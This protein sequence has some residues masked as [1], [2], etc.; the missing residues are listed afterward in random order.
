MVKRTPTLT[1]AAP[2]VIGHRGASGYRPEHTLAAYDLA[3]EQGVSYIEPD[4]VMTR[5]RVL[6]VRHEPVLAS[7]D[8]AGAVVEATTNVH[9]LPQYASRR[10]TRTVDGTA[11]TGW[12]AQ[13]FTLA[14]IKT[15]KARERLPAIRPGNVAFLDETIPTLQEVIDLATVRSA[16]LG[17]TIGVYPEL[18]HGTYHF[19]AGLPMEDA[20]VRTLAANG[21][22]DATAPVYV[23]SFEVGNLKYLRSIT[24]V[25]LVQLFN[26]GGKP[27]DFIITG[28]RRTYSALATAAGLLEIA[29]YADGVG[30]NKLHVIA[31]NADGTLGAATS[32]TAD[33]HAA[34]L[35][36]HAW[37]FRAENT[38]LPANFKRGSDPAQLGDL[39][40]ELSA[41]LATGIDGFFTDH[42]DLGVAAVL[43]R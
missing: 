6:I 3:I 41:H 22:N 4:L 34:G 11:V 20:L 15:L 39:R 26:V 18:K 21:W 17:R 5:D 12:F 37:T 25:K 2:I 9:E 1:G 29:T 42:P 8:P 33:A 30:A 35:E 28:D 10:T 14:E 13:D 24:R 27:Y 7:V 16:Q 19:A 31:R 40:G 36:V 38:F 23:Q 43:D 32:L